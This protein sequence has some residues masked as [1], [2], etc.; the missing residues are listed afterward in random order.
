MLNSVLARFAQSFAKADCRKVNLKPNSR[1]KKGAFAL[2]VR[3]T[4][5]LVIEAAP[6]GSR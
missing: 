4:T 5:L 1:R 2:P 3:E 6:G